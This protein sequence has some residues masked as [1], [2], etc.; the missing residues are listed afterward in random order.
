MYEHSNHDQQRFARDCILS[1]DIK[2]HVLMSCDS[3][4][5]SILGPVLSENPQDCPVLRN[6]A[7]QDSINWLAHQP[8]LRPGSPQESCRNL[9][10]TIKTS[11]LCRT[12]QEVKNFN[13]FNFNSLSGWGHKPGMLSNV[14]HL[15]A[16]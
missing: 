3:S 4:H 11:I 16:W 5:A 12:Q 14:M 8:I 1:H 13:N 6:I 15:S 2:A 10:G 9:W 7:P